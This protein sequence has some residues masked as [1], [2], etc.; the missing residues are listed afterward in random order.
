LEGVNSPDD[1]LRERAPE[2]RLTDALCDATGSRAKA[3]K[4]VSNEEHLD[5]FKSCQCADKPTNIESSISNALDIPN[6]LEPFFLQEVD[7]PFRFS[8]SQGKSYNI[9]V[10]KQNETL[11]HGTEGSVFR[12]S[13]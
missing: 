4:I 13:S 3:F 5:I 6:V 7:N 9:T 1:A 11:G 2:V 8:L 12:N 10:N